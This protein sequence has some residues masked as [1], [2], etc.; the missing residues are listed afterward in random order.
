MLAAG[1]RSRR[2]AAEGRCRGR[3]HRAEYTAR[4]SVRVVEAQNILREDLPLPVAV[5]RASVLERNLAEFQQFSEAAGVLL[6]P[7]GKTTMP[8][9]LSGRQDA[10]GGWCSPFAIGGR[11]R[12]PRQHG[13]P[14]IFYA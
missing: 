8:P 2:P 14:R 12:A 5:L 11:A 4:S 9:A 10:A 6:C 13:V 3:R 1:S 7:H